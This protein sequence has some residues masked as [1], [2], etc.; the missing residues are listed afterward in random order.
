MILFA[1]TKFHKQK[2]DLAYTSFWGKK[3][4]MMNKVTVLIAGNKGCL[5]AYELHMSKKIKIKLDAIHTNLQ[6]KSEHSHFKITYQ[7]Y[8][9]SWRL[10][11][12]LKNINK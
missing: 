10:I 9:K 12:I 5:Y 1:I 6:I 7:N 3:Q 4:C 2:H 8:M 11:L